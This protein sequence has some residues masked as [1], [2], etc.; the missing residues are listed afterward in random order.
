M[1]KHPPWTP[2]IRRFNAS[3]RYGISYWLWGDADVVDTLTA[4]FGINK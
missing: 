2:P 3:V 1:L 4:R